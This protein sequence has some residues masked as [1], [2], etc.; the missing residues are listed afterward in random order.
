MKVKVTT[1][2]NEICTQIIC[3]RKSLSQWAIVESDDMFQSEHFCGGFD[4]DEKA[5]CLSY[6]DANRKE[7]WF[8]LTLR[9]VEAITQGELFEVMARPA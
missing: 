4:A 5:F 9:E 1:E 6:Y 7:Y 8:L 2:F 3:E